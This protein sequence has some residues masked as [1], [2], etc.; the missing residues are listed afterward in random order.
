MSAVRRTS[1]SPAG[2]LRSSTPGSTGFTGANARPDGAFLCVTLNRDRLVGKVDAATGET[3]AAMHTGEAPRSAV[4]SADGTALYVAN[5]ES[6][7]V[8]KVATADMEVLQTVEVGH[9][10]IGV[11]LDEAT[12]QLWVACY[13]GTITV[14]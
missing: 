6:G 1:C 9:H 13:S 12:R 14:L 3:V 10:P 8:A 4:L 11:T 2:R 7:T 5:Y